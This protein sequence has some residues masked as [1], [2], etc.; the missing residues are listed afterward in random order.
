MTVAPRFVAFALSLAALIAAPSPAGEINPP[1]GPISPTGVT[2]ISPAHL[3]SIPYVIT[4]PGSYRLAGNLNAAL[5]PP[6][7]GALIDIRASRVTLD[8]G[9]FT[10]IG[11]NSTVGI[12][13]GIESGITIT[14]GTISACECGVVAE[15]SNSHISRLL[16][17][18]SLGDGLRAGGHSIIENCR[19]DDNGIFGI[20]VG[21]GSR[22]TQCIASNNAS[23]ASGGGIQVTG[24][25]VTIEDCTIMQNG[26]SVRPH[27]GVGIYAVGGLTVARCMIARN[28]MGTNGGYGIEAISTS[29]KV[30]INDCRILENG[31]QS[32]AANS[33]GLWLD[34]DSIMRRCTIDSNHGIG[35]RIGERCDVSECRI[36]GLSTM[37]IAMSVIGSN[38]RIH[39]NAFSS[40]V[41]LLD[42]NG[43]ANIVTS[44][45]FTL[46]DDNVIE[47]GAFN[48]VAPLVTS[49]GLATL[50]NPAANFR[51]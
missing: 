38:G 8:L 32:A 51:Q 2:I 3:T 50:T 21:F 40:G 46:W 42:I 15:N 26:S 9:G 7:S 4:Q 20:V 23:R 19:A 16:V 36:S 35:V 14:N 31:R 48:M 24:G 27:R 47:A 29:G 6:M 22:V 44:N 25:F 30:E 18:G 17:R 41:T 12:T 49:T 39:A 13:V 34:Q 28:G 5:Y 11:N 37:Y 33:G 1:P 43:S 10:L 45:T